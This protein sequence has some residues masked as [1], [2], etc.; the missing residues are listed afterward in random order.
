MPIDLH[1]ETLG[2]ARAARLAARMNPSEARRLGMTPERIQQALGWFADPRF[3]GQE[4]AARAVTRFAG[5]HSGVD[6]AWRYDTLFE[7][8]RDHGLLPLR[9]TRWQVQASKRINRQ[10]AALR[11]VGHR[12]RIARQSAVHYLAFL[13]RALADIR[14]VGR[15]PGGELEP[16]AR[17]LMHR[18]WSAERSED[19]SLLSDLLPWLSAFAAFAGQPPLH[20]G[21]QVATLRAMGKLPSPEILLELKRDP[22]EAPLPGERHAVITVDS[23]LLCFGKGMRFGAFASLTRGAVLLVD[24]AAD[25]MGRPWGAEM[26]SPHPSEARMASCL[27]P[28][29]PMLGTAALLSSM[30]LLDA[31]GIE[32]VSVRGE[33]RKA[34]LVK[35]HDR[36][37]WLDATDA[38]DVGRHALPKDPKVLI[39]AAAQAYLT[40]AGQGLFSLV[41]QFFARR[42]DPS[43]VRIAQL[44]HIFRMKAFP[45]DHFTEAL[46]RTLM[47]RFAFAREDYGA[48]AARIDR[49]VDQAIAGRLLPPGIPVVTLAAAG[50]H[51]CVF[52][53]PL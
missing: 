38:P 24:L 9:S 48:I 49:H 21:V 34:L 45:R 10:P 32:E 46:S 4:E 5:R 28:Q 23:S 53:S 30:K 43:Q 3:S 52:R 12:L 31:Y 20:G 39:D 40:M 11:E 15:Q 19:A 27:W 1:R 18:L 44:R 17:L 51:G 13:Q 6:A 8:V 47:L 36:H 22:F 41:P 26:P 16:G 29:Q 50:A 25:G 33:V 7:R 37:R 2:L 42:D 35:F 14:A